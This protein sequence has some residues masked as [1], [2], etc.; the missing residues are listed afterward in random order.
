MNLMKK[1]ELCF[2]LSEE[3]GY[4]IPDL[5]PKNEPDLDHWKQKDCLCFEYH[6]DILPSSVFLRA[7]VRLH[8]LI[9]K[10]SYW[11]SGVI[12]SDGDNKALLKADYEDKTV[13]I[14]VMG[15]AKG[16][17][18]FLKA[19]RQQFEHIHSTISKL[20]VKQKI[21]YKNVALDY[22]NLLKYEKRGDLFPYIPELDEEVDIVQ[23][24]DGIDTPRPASFQARKRLAK[25]T[26]A[27]NLSRSDAL[28]Q[29]KNVSKVQFM[30]LVF[31]YKAP[32]EYL[33]DENNAIVEQ[34]IR[35]LEYVEQKE[36]GFEPLLE[37]L[38]EIIQ[39]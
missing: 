35:L 10:Q 24:L 25:T 26:R 21:P 8:T 6:Y 27:G 30:E 23:L 14:W 4:L 9:H 7:M 13:F 22:E 12:L 38:A 2:A 28:R 18:A 5:L 17:R 34:A 1:F 20:V 39:H 19:I 3:Q 31:V 36:E 33:P 16:R 37:V 15:Y 32:K 29:L 11:Y